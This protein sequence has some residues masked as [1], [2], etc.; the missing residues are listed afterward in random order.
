MKYFKK[1]L[2][3]LLTLLIIIV[4]LSVYVFTTQALFSY[5]VD[6]L[7]SAYNKDIIMTFIFIV[8]YMLLPTLVFFSTNIYDGIYRTISK[9]LKF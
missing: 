7:F 9:K 6:E 3:H 1:L 4:V 5:F 2:T 8:Y